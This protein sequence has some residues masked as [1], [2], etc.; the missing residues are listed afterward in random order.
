MKVIQFLRE[1]EQAS[2]RYGVTQF[3]D[4]TD[5]EKKRFLGF[6]PELA[7]PGNYVIND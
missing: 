1:T 7:L 4:F 3:A 6:K 2:G 5:A